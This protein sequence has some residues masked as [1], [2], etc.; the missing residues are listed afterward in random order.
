MEAVFEEFRE[1]Q[2]IMEKSYIDLVLYSNG[3]VSLQDIY[4]MPNEMIKSLKS[5]L[6]EKIK[7]TSS[8]FGI[9]M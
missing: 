3:A 5:E 2:E 9:G 8:I 1:N 6:E 4:N 7:N